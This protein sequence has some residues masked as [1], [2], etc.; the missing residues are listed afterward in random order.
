MSLE[1]IYAEQDEE[2]ESTFA[3]LR[4]HENEIENEH[5]NVG[6]T[7]DDA[8]LLPKFIRNNLKDLQSTLVPFVAEI[9]LMVRIGGTRRTAKFLSEELGHKMSRKPIETLMMKVNKGMLVVTQEDLERV[10]TS[11][12]LARKFVQKA[13]WLVDPQS[14]VLITPEAPVKPRGKR[15]RP[16]KVSPTGAEVVEASGTI[17]PKTQDLDDTQRVKAIFQARQ[18]EQPNE[19]SQKPNLGVL[20]MNIKDPRIAEEHR[21]PLENLM[22]RKRAMIAGKP[23]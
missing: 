16:K 17:G 23:V 5:E 11:H 18:G 3:P 22:A 8:V 4:E 2:Q 6:M 15:G 21:G 9:V 10:A 7:E 13:P 19:M 1:T 20:G 14:R 12:P